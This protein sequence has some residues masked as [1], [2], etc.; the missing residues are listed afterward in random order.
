VLPPH[1]QIRLI[2]KGA[3]IMS[4][5]S[6]VR[7]C[8]LFAI[9]TRIHA[10]KTALNSFYPFCF[11]RKA[12]TV[13]SIAPQP[14]GAVTAWCMISSFEDGT[15]TTRLYN[16]SQRGSRGCRRHY[17]RAKRERILAQYS[18]HT[19]YLTSCDNC[20]GTDSPEPISTS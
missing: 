13:K 3:S 1:V 19:S 11:Y 7:K 17:Q 4:A 6:L 16:A 20:P 9:T 18:S 8:A 5:C 10:I 12:C 2:E 14:I 15:P